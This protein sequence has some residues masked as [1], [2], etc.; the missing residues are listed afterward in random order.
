VPAP[1]PAARWSALHHGIEPSSVP[2]LVPWLRLLWA[3]ARP[4][5]AVRVPATAVTLAGVVF[6]LDAAVF[7]SSLPLAAAGCVVVAVVCDGLDG[8]VAVM[9]RGDTRLGAM[10]DAIADRVCDVL[11]AVVLLRCG[12]PW[13]LALCFG[14]LAVGVDLVRRLRRV[15]ARITVAE[16]PTWAVCAFLACVSSSVTSAAWPQWVCGGVGVALGLVAVAQLR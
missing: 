13:G 16:R 10:A 1:D 9:G 12:A 2:G 4:L 11:F 5:V 15:P 7:A 3:L 14:L 8:A 6:A